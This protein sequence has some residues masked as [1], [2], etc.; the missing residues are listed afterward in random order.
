MVVFKPFRTVRVSAEGHRVSTFEL[1][2]D[3]VFVF[4][5]TQTTALMSHERTAYGV[6]QGLIILALLWWSWVAFSWLCNQAHADE[7]IMRAGMMAAM[8]VMFLATIAIPEAYVRF[9]GAM[10]GALVLAVAYAVLR[11]IHTALYIIAADDDQDLRKQV[12]R[13]S[14]ATV[15]GSGL[16]IAGAIIGGHAQTWLWLAGLLTE[17]ALTY[18]LARGGDWRIRS[19]VH[20]TERYG[21]IV[22]LAL[23]ESIIALGVGATE[24]PFGSAIL[25]GALLGVGLSICLWWLYFDMTALEAE[26]I[27]EGLDGGERASMATDA[28]SYLHFVII[29][30]IILSAL[31]IE[32]ALSHIDDSTR[33]GWFGSA[34][35]LG[36][37][38]LY[39]AGHTLFWRRVGG[40][41]KMSRVAT[42][43]L[44]LALIP[45]GA[46]VPPLA[47]MTLVFGVCAALV[48]FETTRYATHRATVRG[49][50]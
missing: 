47:A 11:G 44:L 46:L 40:S 37:T 36:G 17:L 18:A 13:S 49:R 35:L 28:Y 8:A 3:V 22:I 12:I 21:L 4:A 30:G 48:A 42:A 2:F 34:H 39:L 26:H 41:W 15:V 31:G 50:L 9:D 33:F 16:I 27:F 25:V 20:W 38:A 5:F 24:L 7:G 43:A 29:T 14:T 1:F 32:T 45:V 23:G 19:A 10:S 6:L